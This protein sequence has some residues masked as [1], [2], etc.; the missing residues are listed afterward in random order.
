MHPAGRGDAN[1]DP[2]GQTQPQRALGCQGLQSPSRS[3]PSPAPGCPKPC[4]AWALPGQPQLHRH[5]KINQFMI[6]LVLQNGWFF[7]TAGHSCCAVLGRVK[8]G[9]PPLPLPPV[10]I[11]SPS[12]PCQAC[13]QRFTGTGTAGPAG[14]VQSRSR[15]M[16]LALTGSE[17]WLFW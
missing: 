6:E 3:T 7:S 12:L 8:R 13:T 17:W 1:K 11:S 16:A 9:L 10:P 4:P 2:G 15:R 5:S 14:K